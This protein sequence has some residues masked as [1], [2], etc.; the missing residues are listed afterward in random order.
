MHLRGVPPVLIDNVR[1]TFDMLY[2]D[3]GGEVTGHVQR[4]MKGRTLDALSAEDCIQT[5]WTKVWANL[6]VVERRPGHGRHDGLRAWVHMITRN[7]VLDLANRARF[8]RHVSLA[9]DGW[10]DYGRLNAGGDAMRSDPGFEA[11]PSTDPHARAVGKEVAGALREAL[12]VMTA[13]QRRCMLGMLAGHDSVRLGE[14]LNRSDRGIRHAILRG[15]RTFEAVAARRGV[16]TC[17]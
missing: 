17:H 9:P 11:L 13:H 14:R 4:L 7:T 15:R 2:G 12:D 6:P 3:L 5:V 10:L 8:R 16:E 1:E